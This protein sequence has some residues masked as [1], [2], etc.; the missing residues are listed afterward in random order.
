MERKKLLK[1]WLLCLTPAF[2]AGV[3]YFLLPFFPSFTEFVF[4]RV[5]FRIFAFPFEFLVS[6]L[7]FSLTEI[8]VLLIPVAVIA[9][10]V[11]FI[12]KLAKSNRRGVLVE[13]TARFVALFTSLFLLVFMINDGAQYSRLSVA[14]LMELPNRQYTKEELYLVTCDLAK[15]TSEAGENIPRDSKGRAQL[16]VSTSQLLKGADDCYNNIAKQYPFLKTGITRV[17]PVMLSHYWSYTG[18]TG[19]YCPWLLEANVNIDVPASELGHTAAHEVAHTMGFAKENECNFLAW[20]ACDESDQPDYKYSGNLAAFIYCSNALY[21][22]DKELFIKAY[23]C[24]SKDVLADLKYR[25]EYW[26]RFEGEVMESSQ[27]ANDTF[28]KANGDQ[29]G[30]LS[31]NKMTELMLR[32]YDKQGA[33]DNQS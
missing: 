24:C 31:Y 19:I 28:I 29:S 32:Y 23:S 15:K 6:L 30:I 11:I 4:T 17:K 16:S 14:K 22:A 33:F 21:K 18:T 13:K 20:L 27:K 2:V 1:K 9:L 10:L 8:V 7:P 25:N 26:N 3:M 5:I 12:I